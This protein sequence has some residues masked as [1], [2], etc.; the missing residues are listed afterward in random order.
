MDPK[1]LIQR[2]PL[3]TLDAAIAGGLGKG[4]L[5][6]VLA[7]HGAGKT[8]FLVAV[9]LDHLLCGER[10][11]HVSLEQKVDHVRDF[12]DQI[13][14]ELA[15]NAHLDDVRSVHLGLERARR[16][17]TYLGGTFKIGRAHV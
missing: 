13:F 14:E 5:G 2:S 7:R 8:P 12:Y 4:N 3:R 10:V 6:I 11:L 16:I 17:H 9:A 1:D 15:R